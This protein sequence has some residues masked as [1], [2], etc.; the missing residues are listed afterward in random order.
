MLTSFWKSLAV[1]IANNVIETNDYTALFNQVI[2]VRGKK[3]IP[4]CGK[5]AQYSVIYNQL[6]IIIILKIWNRIKTNLTAAPVLKMFWCQSESS[7][8]RRNI[9]KCTGLWQLHAKFWAE[10]IFGQGHELGRVEDKKHQCLMHGS[11]FFF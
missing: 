8:K 7:K 4:F 2:T 6:Y 9:F 1:D 5:K 10:K 3:I 11:T